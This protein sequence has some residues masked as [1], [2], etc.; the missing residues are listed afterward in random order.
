MSIVATNVDAVCEMIERDLHIIYREIQA[1]L[2]ID[3]KVVHTI[4]HDH[5]SV[6]KFCKCWIPHNMT[7]APKHA[8]IK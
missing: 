1:F 4:L 5:L 8:H 2:G 7:E 6:R 3:M